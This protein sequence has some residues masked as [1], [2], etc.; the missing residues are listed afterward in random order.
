MKHL[1][2]VCVIGAGPCGL[3]SAKNLLQQGLTD[4]SVFEKNNQLGGNWIYGDQN[5]HSS[6]YETTHI[7]SSKRLSE[8]EDFPMPSS[9]PDYPSHRQI[10]RYF[11]DYADHFGLHPF[12]Q[13]N[14]EI[15]DVT[16]NELNQW[17]VTYANNAG[18]HTEIFDAVLVANGHHWDPK[19]PIYPGVF[20]GLQLHSHQYKKAAPFANKRVLVVGAGNSAC[21][22]AVETARVS[23]KTCISMR[24]GQH[25]FPKFMFGKPTDRVFS[26]ISWMP[27]WC[28]QYLATFIIRLLQNRYAKYNLPQPNN[29]PLET[30]PTINSELLYFI[31]HGKI[32]PH[33][34][35]EKF[36]G[37]KVYFADGRQE[38]FDVIIFATG[39]NIRFPF[40][41]DDLIDFSAL[42]Q[43]PLYRKMMHPELDHLYFIGLF[44]PQGCIWPLA[45]HQA[46]IAAGIITG[47]LKKPVHLHAKINKEIKT[48]RNRFSNSARHVL[49]VEY[50]TF[51]KQLLNELNNL[52]RSITS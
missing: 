46:K 34:G 28:K 52:E 50:R 11:N 9:Y 43:R 27:M 2:K 38:A 8:F 37:D 10:L 44:Q 22:I 14:T 21:D 16:R 41:N 20:N 12:I 30:H 19:M 36:D 51:R 24:T 23:S 25:I 35:I 47:R 48:T 3:A 13:F 17:R 26:K 49:E 4:V 1:P 6:I 5:T 32:H 40:L 42:T 31:R 29:K 33:Q 45:D 15:L 39:Y 18:R 7:I